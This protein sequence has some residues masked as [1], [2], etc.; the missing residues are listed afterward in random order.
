[1]ITNAIMF[2]DKIYTKKWLQD[3]TT[4]KYPLNVLEPYPFEEALTKLVDLPTG[5]HV[6][7]PT[8]GRQ[9]N[10]VALIE[11]TNNGFTL[12]PC[13]DYLSLEEITNK[14]IEIKTARINTPIK[15]K[16]HLIWF[17]EEWIYPHE[18]LHKFTDDIRCPPIFR[19]CGREKVYFVCMTPLYFKYTGESPSGWLKRKYM[20]LDLEGVIRN[21]NEMDLTYADKASILKSEEKN[22]DI[23]PFGEKIEGIKEAIEQVNIEIGKKIRLFRNRSWSVD[24]TFDRNNN[25][26][27]IEVNHSPGTQFKG[28]TWKK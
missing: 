14:L 21:K 3:N 5:S 11:K 15:I 10:G 13:K 17:V 12:F 16:T 20:W 7:K 9:S 2:W 27:I 28:F 22:I 8:I 25:F 19:F 6:W 1:M 26:V 4:F 24:G 23:A 18:K